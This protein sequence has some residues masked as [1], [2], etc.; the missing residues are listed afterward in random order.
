MI[1]LT[2]KKLSVI[3][4]LFIFIFLSDVSNAQQK[5][6]NI[7]NI[8]PVNFGNYDGVTDR[9]ANGSVTIFCG[10]GIRNKPV[11][12]QLDRGLYS[13]SYSIRYMKHTSLNEYLGYNLYTDAGRTIIWGDGSGGSSIVTLT[14]MNN[15]TINVPIYGRLPAMQS[16][17]FGDYSDTVIL[18]I[19]Y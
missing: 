2:M 12:I 6:C 8:S 7:T 15:Q 5:A 1:T 9:D 18:T 4:I 16:G 17:S 10:P 3:L 11:V 13:Q 19:L 14:N